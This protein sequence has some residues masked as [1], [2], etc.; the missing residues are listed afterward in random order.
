MLLLQG[1]TQEPNAPAMALRSIASK[2]GASANA[3]EQLQML[4]KCAGKL[5]GL[6]DHAR[7]WGNRVMGCTAQVHL[8]A[9]ICNPC[10]TIM[11]MLCSAPN[12]GSIQSTRR[13]HVAQLKQALSRQV[14]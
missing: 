8:L 11:R 1:V 4:M 10:R 9:C 5:P 7:T 2:L 13:L 6:P 12:L 3:K 14:G